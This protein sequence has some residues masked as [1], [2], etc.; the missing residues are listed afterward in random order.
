LTIAAPEVASSDGPP[1]DVLVAEALTQTIREV[2]AAGVRAQVIF[3]AS[4]ETQN[5]RVHATL[6]WIVT[7]HETAPSGEGEELDFGGR[8]GESSLDASRFE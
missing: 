2:H 6:P 8:Y 3:D 5:Q 4:H 7:P 1:A